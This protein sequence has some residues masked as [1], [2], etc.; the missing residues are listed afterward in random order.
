MKTI[1]DESVH[2]VVTSPPY[3][4]LRDYGTASWEGGD[5]A[6]DHIPEFK[7]RSTRA[8]DTL[9]GIGKYGYDGQNPIYKD[10]CGKCGAVRVDQQIGLEET[11]EM[12]VAKMV[13]AFREVRRILRQTQSS[14]SKVA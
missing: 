4:G 6:C 11:P 5:P 13:D 3:Y 1:A 7:H 12:Y 10:I 2:C 14:K 9:S 8:N